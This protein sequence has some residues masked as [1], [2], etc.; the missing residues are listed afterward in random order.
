MHINII[1]F[2]II[3][4]TYICTYVHKHV[5]YVYYMYLYIYRKE[6]LK[7]V[8]NNSLVF[9]NRR[10][11]VKKKLLSLEVHNVII[12]NCFVHGG[13]KDRQMSNLFF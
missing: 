9:N 7:Q 4:Y 10:K 8:L 1:E 3:M 6:H 2:E 12:N 13:I 5:Y 11:S